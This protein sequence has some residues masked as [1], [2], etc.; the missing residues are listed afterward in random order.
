MNKEIWKDVVGYEGRYKVSN[1]GNVMSVNYL[2]TG[3]AQLLSKCPM[4]RG[5]LVVALSKGNKAK[6][7]LVHRLVAEAFLPNPDNLPQINHKDKD[8]WN[9]SVD[10]LEWCDSQYNV[11]YSVG[12]AVRCIELDRVFESAI[13]AGREMGICDN[14]IRKCYKGIYKTAGGYHWERV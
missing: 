3:K 13:E 12:K 6:L 8:R 7:K 4:N 1:L 9:N 10:N 5:Y 11:V 2:N 14:S